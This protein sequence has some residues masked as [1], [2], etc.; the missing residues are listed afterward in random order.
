MAEE[1]PEVSTEAPSF[2]KSN[3]LGAIISATLEASKKIGAAISKVA[4]DIIG[5]ILKQ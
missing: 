4:N 5:M 3:N 1:T 2:E